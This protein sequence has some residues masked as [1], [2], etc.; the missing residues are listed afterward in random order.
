M[1]GLKVLA[2]GFDMDEKVKI[3][4]LLTAMGGIWQT[5]ASS[6]VSL[7]IVKNVLPEKY[8]WELNILKKP[9]VTIQWLY[10]CW[11][12]HRV[13]P[14]ES[15]RV[16]PFS[17]LTIC[18][19][20]F[21]TA[22]DK[23]KV[24]RR[25]GHL[26]IVFPKWFDQSIA[27]RGNVLYDGRRKQQCDSIGQNLKNGMSSTR[28]EIVEWV[29][30]GGGEVVK[31]RGEMNVNFIIECHGVIPRPIIGSQ[32]YVSAHRVQ[33]CLESYSLFATSCQVPFPGF[34]S[35]R[36]CVSQYE[37][38]DRLL[39]R[40]L[41]FILGAK[42]VRKLTRK[43]TH[44]SCKFTS[45]P[46]YEAACKWGIQS[47]TSDWSY[48]CV[49]QNKVVSLDPFCPKEV[50]AQDLEAGLCTVSQFPTQ[51]AQMMSA[52]VP[53]QFM[54][55]SQDLRTPALGVENES[56]IGGRYDD[57]RDE[58][59]QSNVPLK[60]ARCLESDHHVTGLYGGFGETKTESQVSD[61]S[62]VKTTEAQ[63]SD[64]T[65]LK[66]FFSSSG[67]DPSSCLKIVGYEEDWSALLQART[68]DSRFLQL[69]ISKD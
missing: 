51:A 48:E 32:I 7:V 22:G 21:P 14:Q 34:Q 63:V 24:A 15:Y 45:G 18:L 16:L 54:S 20:Q 1:D 58:A 9:I 60:R 38:K 64:P 31:D 55:Q 61:T 17:G 65:C 53:F 40:N 11:S 10:Q 33:S 35:F 67:S 8:K 66:S 37:K 13:V 30:Q 68:I 5:E 41:C 3:E 49:R 27:R 46:K 6:D 56:I 52:D 47:V 4:K 23:Y 59:E 29:N 57:P 42:F 25:W 44:L 12:E 50:T 36:F 2:S 28:A 19:T 26:H 69:N 43:V 62:S 39:L